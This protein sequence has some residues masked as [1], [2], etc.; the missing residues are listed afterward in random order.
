VNRFQQA[1]EARWASCL[2]SISFEGDPNRHICE[3]LTVPERTGTRNNYSYFRDA[4]ETMSSCFD[5]HRKQM[6]VDLW[7]SSSGKVG[8]IR[9]RSI[10]WSPTT[11]HLRRVVAQIEPLNIS[12]SPFHLMNGGA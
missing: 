7:R 6:C 4:S 2:V 8:A 12:V 5:I 3:M 1:N 11:F 10:L 9:G